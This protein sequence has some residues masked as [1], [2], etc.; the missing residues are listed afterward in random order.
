MNTTG[1]AYGSYTFNKKVGK[2]Q[3]QGRTPLNQTL[4]HLG[5]FLTEGEAKKALNNFNFDFF[6]KH[7]NLLPRCIGVSRKI[8]KFIFVLPFGNKTKFAFQSADLDEVVDFKNQF[9][10]KL[11]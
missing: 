7:S 6:E 5:V 8:R 10:L 3:A 9:I 1:T 11:I 2:Y 4:K